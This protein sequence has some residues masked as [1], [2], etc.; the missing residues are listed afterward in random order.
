MIDDR[1]I[2]F[3]AR[4]AVRHLDDER[5]L[6][7]NPLFKRDAERPHDA[8]RAVVLRALEALRGVQVEHHEI[9]VRCDVRREPHKQV[10]DALSISRRQ[11]YRERQ[12]ALL[13]LGDA[14]LHERDRATTPIVTPLPDPRET[15]M[16]FIDML[17][18]C[19]QHEAVWREAHALAA[20][21]DD[22]Q[23]A[24]SLYV[25]ASEAARFLGDHDR[26]AEG[27]RRATQLLIALDEDS[28]SL[29][30]TLWVAI[31]EIALYLA[32][33][34]FADSRATFAQMM[35]RIDERTLHGP[36]ATLLEILLSHVV[37]IDL[38]CGDWTGGRALLGRA[39]ALMTR[40]AEAA[41][42]RA[43]RL[44]LSGR[45]ALQGEGDARRAVAEQRA[46]LDAAQRAGQL[47][48]AGHAAA[49]LGIALD[50]QNEP[51]AVRHIT[52]GLDVVGRFSDDECATLLAESL[53]TLLRAGAAD[54][55][56]ERLA[57]LRAR[58][59]LAPRTTPLLDLSEARVLMEANDARG[60][61]ER[62]NDARL[63]LEAQGQYPWAREAQLLEVESL[64]ALRQPVRA[65][66]AL[67]EL[68]ELVHNGGRVQ[69]L[70]RVEAL[71]TFLAR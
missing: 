64:V 53:P 2:A 47:R 3:A 52:Y 61:L 65:R 35:A 11:F 9:V 59:R 19:G 31:G 30:S 60:A 55:V 48:Q 44:R 66:R 12:R 39:E 69:T 50:D 22:A 70:H 45:I 8:L 68:R 27:V 40:T 26:A 21:V 29:A 6:R 37:S 71:G 57:G 58:S 54:Q 10:V 13:R 33:A 14:I 46:A 15:A 18:G 17:R 24:I 43:V 4:D 49:E 1:V 7:A 63:R 62:A 5:A 36:E 25:V 38:A 34:R 20:Q 32:Q 16:T 67:R 56:R 51:E 42:G 41:R 23:F 28:R